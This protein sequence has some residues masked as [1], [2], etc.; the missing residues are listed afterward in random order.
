MVLVGINIYLPGWEFGI[1]CG[2]LCGLV[3]LPSWFPG[4]AL[5]NLGLIGTLFIALIFS[6]PLL[7][8]G[9]MTRVPFFSAFGRYQIAIADNEE[10]S[11][12][13]SGRLGARND[14]TPER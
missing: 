12:A 13:G 11:F 14:S 3:P 7:I 4:S 2:I 5:P 10:R 6:V 1:F 8:A 9:V